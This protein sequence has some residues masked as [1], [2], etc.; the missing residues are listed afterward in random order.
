MRRELATLTTLLLLCAIIPHPVSAID[1]DIY[2][3]TT[4][5]I[6]GEPVG[7]GYTFLITNIRSNDD[8]VVETDSNGFF[9]QYVGTNLQLDD[10]MKIE[11]QF[12]TAYIYDGQFAVSMYEIQHDLIS[13]DMRF[14]SILDDPG[15][16]FDSKSVGDIWHNDYVKCGSISSTEVDLKR[17]A[18]NSHDFNIMCKYQY[19]LSDI[20]AV[21]GV[22]LDD[23]A[24]Y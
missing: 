16:Y 12:A 17:E 2:W 24:Q 9:R 23:E 20:L 14:L 15:D 22:P 8:W 10:T 3:E 11:P 13:Y 4:A 5:Y 21:D 18:T 7:S 6:D 1:P 19:H